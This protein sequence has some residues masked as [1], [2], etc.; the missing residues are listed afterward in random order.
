MTTTTTLIEQDFDFQELQ[1][2]VQADFIEMPGMS[3]TY[4]Q[5]VRLWAC[6]PVVCRAVLESLVESQFLVRNRRAAFT[7]RDS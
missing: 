5:A 2:R 1:R 7:R 6:H 4:E 3:L